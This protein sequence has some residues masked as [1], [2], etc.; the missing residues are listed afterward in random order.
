MGSQNKLNWGQS[1]V[2]RSKNLQNAEKNNTQVQN[3]KRSVDY[4]IKVVILPKNAA[5]L[6]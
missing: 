2:K 4:N 1:K 6:K 5:K 3:R